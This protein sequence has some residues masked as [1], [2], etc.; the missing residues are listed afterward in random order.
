M[1]P[2][3]VLADPKAW[4]GKVVEL[5]GFFVFGREHMAIYSS[6][7]DT[8]SD[9]GIW[10]GNASLRRA[11]AKALSR[12]EVVIHGTFHHTGQRGFG[13]LGQWPAEIR[14]ANYFEAFSGE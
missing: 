10:L 6:T 14:E 11:K 7:E 4:D 2:S 5:T 8:M 12:K 1:S 3:E 13:H 9:A